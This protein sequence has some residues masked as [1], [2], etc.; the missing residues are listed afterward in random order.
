MPLRADL[1]SA[2][3][4]GTTLLRFRN[5][6]LQSTQENVDHRVGDGDQLQRAISVALSSERGPDLIG[7]EHGADSR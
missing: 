4:L 1:E 3:R 6:V 2:C 5:V 7:T